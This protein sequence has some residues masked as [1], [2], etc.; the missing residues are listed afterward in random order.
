[1]IRF[2]NVQPLIACLLAAACMPTIP[3]L[4]PSAQVSIPNEWRSSSETGVPISA[5]WWR[6]FEDPDLD[7]LV[8]EARKNNA[9][10]AIAVERV[11]EARAQIGVA[12]SAL[13]PTLDLQ[14]GVAQSR[15][16]SAFGTGANGLAAQPQFQ[17]AYEIDL[18]DRLGDQVA[19]ST[20]NA[21][22]AAA[23]EQAAFLAVTAATASGYVTLLTLDGQRTVLRS[24]L[25]SRSEALRI[26]RSRA[27][28]GYTSQLE[29]RQAEAEY[30]ATKAQLPPVELGIARAENALS[31]LTGTSPHR[32][33]RGSLRTMALPEPPVTLPSL[34]TAGRPDIVQAAYQ[35]VAADRSL[36]AAR[37]DFLP[38]IR[39]AASVGSVLSSQLDGPVSIW[40]LGSSVLAPLFAGGRLT[41][42]FEAADARR[43]QAAIGYRRVV[44]GA[45]REVEDQLAAVARFKEQ[46]DDLIAQRDAVAEALR[47]A[48]N[49]YQA[50]Y[51]TYL[52]QLDAQRLLL[53]VQ[54]A[55]V[56]NRN[57]RLSAVIA[58][59]QAEGGGEL[60][61]WAGRPSRSTDDL[62]IPYTK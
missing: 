20:A 10:V 60:A 14:G 40:S 5:E 30:Q 12:R 44:L 52:E 23:A 25:E 35:L 22:A 54:L 13:R 27:R 48:T 43:A 9:D 58:L 34:V 26:A 38:R 29:L 21:I 19:A 53:Q 45:F 46:R 49:R 3:P 61:D 47:H 42:T 16:L 39:L 6:G 36:A 4:P 56:Q 62:P 59:I 55:L 7:Q 1:M 37:K 57:D 33:E 24:T 17:A 18:F 28:I 8:Q 2:R 32:I 41:A 11:R 31:L 15:A 50:G 51:S